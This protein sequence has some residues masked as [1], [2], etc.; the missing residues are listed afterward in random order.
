MSFC[1][2]ILTALRQPPSLSPYPAATTPTGTTVKT[3]LELAAAVQAFSA[4]ASTA[5]QVASKKPIVQN[6]LLQCNT[7]YLMYNN[8]SSLPDQGLPYDFTLIVA[9]NGILNI[10]GPSTCGDSPPV[11]LGSMDQSPPPKEYI[12]VGLASQNK[13][14]N[15]VSSEKDAGKVTL[16]VQNVVFDGSDKMR[17]A[18]YINYAKQVTLQNVVVKDCMAGDD[19]GGGA[20]ITEGSSLVIKGGSFSDNYAQGDGGVIYAYAMNVPIAKMVTVTGATFTNNA[21]QGGNGGVIAVGKNVL[22]KTAISFSGCKFSGNTA[23]NDC[24]IL[25]SD[26]SDFTDGTKLNTFKAGAAPSYSFKSCTFTGGRRHVG[27]RGWEV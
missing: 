1:N 18:F 7:Q 24:S 16:V 10:I 8:D 9:G 15:D 14:P 22:S 11:I 13:S 2:I 17:T 4:A 25:F 23:S 21:A 19:H 27:R 26:R 20:I 3:G 6:I 5:S 12:Y